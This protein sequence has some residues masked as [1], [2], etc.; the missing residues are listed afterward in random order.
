M[1]NRDDQATVLATP[2]GTVIY[3]TSPRGIG[4]ATLQAAAWPAKI[5]V[6]PRYA[7]D[8]AFG[9]LEGFA[10]YVF[11]AAGGDGVLVE[12]KIVTDAQGLV[13]QIE[14]P[15]SLRSGRVQLSWVDAYR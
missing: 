13:V 7:S 5:A 4:E 1:K 2:T 8:R 14:L 11:P 6:R 12:H 10:C 15:A 3:I 9:R